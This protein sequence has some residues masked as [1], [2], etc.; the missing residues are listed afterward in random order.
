MRVNG[1]MRE[2]HREP[3]ASLPRLRIAMML[4]SDEPGGAEMMVFRLSEELRRR[5]H[6]IV[7]IGPE[8]GVGWLGDVF[9]RAGFSPEIFRIQRP[10]DPR[11]VRGLWRCSD[12][13][14]STSSTATSSRWRFTGRRRRDCWACPT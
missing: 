6:T 13:T 14:E 1:V 4:E 11:C 3:M 12:I 2:R 9:R 7:P 8:H 10:I 5:G